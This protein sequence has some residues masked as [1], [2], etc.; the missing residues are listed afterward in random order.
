MIFKKKLIV[1]FYPKNGVDNIK[2]GMKREEVE[3]VLKSEYKQ[4]KTFQKKSTDYYFENSLTFSFEDD[5]T[6]SF[7]EV[8]SPPPIYLKINDI[9]TWDIP[10]NKLLEII[11]EFD[12]IDTDLFEYEYNP[13]FKNN[14]ITF[15]DLDEQYDHIGNKK[16]PK[17]GAIGIGDQ[18]Y[19]D[20]IKNIGKE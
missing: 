20:G 9:K 5:S 10:G 12:V 17:W 14:I 2:F 1:T 19:Y 6:L 8:S 13:T 7:I 3:K 4:D 18:R 15:Y 11:K 16:T